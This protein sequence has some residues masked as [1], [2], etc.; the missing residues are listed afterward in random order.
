MSCLRSTFLGINLFWLRSYLRKSVYD[1]NGDLITAR[2]DFKPNDTFTKTSIT[3]LPTDKAHIFHS[4][5]KYFWDSARG[6]HYV[7]DILISG[8]HNVCLISR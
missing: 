8:K 6:Y 4:R 3:I 7:L 2:F 1:G 5:K